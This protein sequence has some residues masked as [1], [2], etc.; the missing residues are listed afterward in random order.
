MDAVKREQWEA[1]GI[2]VESALGRFMGNEM[3][4]E[5]FMK[6]FL[7]DSNFENLRKALAAKDLD[8]AIMRESFDDGFIRFVY[9]A[10]GRAPCRQTGGSG[11][12][13]GGD[14]SGL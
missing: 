5:R 3:L 2:D 13:D 4:L 6:K 11:R 10:S 1:A 8:A 7:E 14:S 12:D 9:K